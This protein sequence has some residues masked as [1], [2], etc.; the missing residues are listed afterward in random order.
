[1]GFSWGLA[2]GRSTGVVVALAPRR[3]YQPLGASER[4]AHFSASDSGPVL[5]ER[6]PGFPDRFAVSFKKTFQ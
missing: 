3:G 2:P 4:W 5:Q 1:M 6:C